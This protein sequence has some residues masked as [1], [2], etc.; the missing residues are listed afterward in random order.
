MSQ[1]MNIGMEKIFFHHILNNPEQ[2][3]KVENYFFK[4]DEIQFIYEVIRNEYLISKVKT[5]PTPQ[6]ILAMVKI[7]DSEK[8]IPDQLIKELLKGDNTKYEDDWV[9]PRFKA[10][11]LSNSAKNHVIKS[12]DYI[13]GIEEINYDNVVD[14]ISKIKNMF[15][16]LTVIDDDDQDVGDDYDDIESHQLSN[17]T[18]KMP[19]GWSCMDRILGGGWDQASLNVLMGETNVGKC[20][21]F[22]TIIKIRNRITGVEECIKIGDLFERIKT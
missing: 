4:S 9:S 2:F 17:T 21:D 13:R 5:V 19:T 1:K 22:Q 10:W 12:V 11:K 16:D 3:Q 14:V 18:K 8:K 20:S 6:Q 15:G 7:N